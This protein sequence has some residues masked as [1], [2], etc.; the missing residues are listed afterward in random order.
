MNLQKIQQ[1]RHL[2]KTRHRNNWQ[3]RRIIDPM[4]YRSDIL[5]GKISKISGYE[6]AVIVRLEKSFIENIP[7]MESVYLEIEGRPVPFFISE[8][9]YKGADILRLSFQWY[10]S[11]EKVR[12]FVGSKVFLTSIRNAGNEYEKTLSLEG[13]TVHTPVNKPL[14]YISE[15]FEN[16]GQILLNIITPDRKSILIPLHEDFI[17]KIDKRSKLLIMDLPDG[18]TELNLL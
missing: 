12:E 4:T 11:D 2:R 3:V 6:G 1:R 16:P 5:L 17:I 9:E 14:G 13:Y 10:E 18:L 15:V 8:Y 7:D